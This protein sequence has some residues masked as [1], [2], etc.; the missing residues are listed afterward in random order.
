MTNEKFIS[1]VREN[2]Q[3][4]FLIALSYTKSREDSEDILQNV[5]LKLWNYTKSFEDETHLNK[6]LTV[7]CVNESKNFLKSPFRKRR[8]ELTELSS[9]YYF[10]SAEKQDV[11]DAVMSLSQ[12]ERT[13]THFFYYEEKSIKEISQILKISETS[14]K[15]RLFRARKNLKNYLGDEWINE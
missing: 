8:S 4:L 15:T 13:V 11:F 2:N 9:E 6:W 10:D 14:V 5:F 1:A 7:V 12:K 3:R